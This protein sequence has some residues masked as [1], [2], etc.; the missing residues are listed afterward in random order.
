VYKRESGWGDGWTW[1]A[2]NGTAYVSCVFSWLLADARDQC[3]ALLSRGYRVRAGGPAVALNPD[4]LADLPV[5]LSPDPPGLSSGT[6]SPSGRGEVRALARHHPAATFT[7]R[8]CVRRCGFCAVPRIEGDL[9]EL[10]DWEPRPVICDNNLLAASKAHFGRVVDR[11]KAAHGR[12]RS[13]KKR[14]RVDFNQGLDARLLTQYHADRLAELDCMVRLA[15]DHL[16]VESQF[17]RAFERLRQAG[18]PKRRIRVY[19]LIGWKDTPE[20]AAYRLQL[21]QGLHLLPFPMRFE[22]LDARERGAYVGPGWSDAEL[23]RFMKYWTNIGRFGSVPF[24]D[25]RLEEC[26]KVGRRTKDG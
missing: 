19:V 6:G 9:V 8:G 1:W 11:L 14:P 13:S 16:A 4:Y 21:I 24:E 17:M 7:T 5:T 25:F 22:P 2:E 26:S 23:R 18:I 15:F 10:D 12:R 20:D 3:I